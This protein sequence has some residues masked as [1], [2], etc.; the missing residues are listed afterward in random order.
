MNSKLRDELRRKWTR[1]R[2][3]KKLENDQAGLCTGCDRKIIVGFHRYDADHRRELRHFEDHEADIANHPNNVDIMHRKCHRE[4]KSQHYAKHGLS[5]WEAMRAKCRAIPYDSHYT[6]SDICQT[7]GCDNLLGDKSE[8]AD[9]CVECQLERNRE[10]NRRIRSTEEGRQKANDASNVS[11]AAP[12]GLYELQQGP[13]REYNNDTSRES[14]RENS[15]PARNWLRD[16]GYP[17]DPIPAITYEGMVACIR[18]TG[19]KYRP[20][21]LQRQ[22]NAE[23]GTG[24]IRPRGT[25]SIKGVPRQSPEV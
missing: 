16:N 7:E 3:I 5:N 4:V 21:H 14:R 19:T 13:L 24:H 22:L 1:A 11:H 17:Y 18:A 2:K 9:F 8:N 20:R 6:N 10:A 25:M 23:F 15:G 12:G